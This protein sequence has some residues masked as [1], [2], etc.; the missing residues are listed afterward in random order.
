MNEIADEGAIAIAAALPH[1][2]SLRKLILRKNCIGARGG[3]AIAASLEQCR[4]TGHHQL[5][6][7]DLA[8]NSI[9]EEARVRLSMQGKRTSTASTNL[10]VV[11]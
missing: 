6:H 8:H 4:A 10:M 2:T 1:T 11:C 5:E 9:V 7:V 3:D